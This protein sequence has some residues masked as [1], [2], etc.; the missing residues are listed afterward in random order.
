MA[1][2]EPM[3]FNKL[4]LK[5]SNTLNDPEKSKQPNM[6]LWSLINQFPS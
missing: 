3:A 4:S 5:R 6:Q 1:M 2:N